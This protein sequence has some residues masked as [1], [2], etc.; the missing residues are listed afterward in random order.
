[1]IDNQLYIYL[2]GVAGVAYILWEVFNGRRVRKQRQQF[3]TRGDLATQQ[4]SDLSLTDSVTLDRSA[5]TIPLSSARSADLP[6]ENAAQSIDGKTPEPNTPGA[7]VSLRNLTLDQDAIERAARERVI[8]EQA[9]L[10]RARAQQAALEQARAQQAERDRIRAEHDR[11]EA[12]RK[13]AEDAERFA[14]AASRVHKQWCEKERKVEAQYNKQ[15]IAVTERL[16]RARR[17]VQDSGVGEA[18][19]NA[20]RMMWHWPALQAKDEWSRPAGMNE[21]VLDPPLAEKSDSHNVISWLWIDRHYRI[22]LDVPDEQ[23]SE[24]E[25]S[26]VLTLQVDGEGVLSIDVSNPVGGAIERWDISGVDALKAGPWMPEF[27]EIIERLKSGEAEK[28]RQMRFE[29]AAGKANRVE[30]GEEQR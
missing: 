9:A 5:S 17:L 11:I 20:L 2:M 10:E 14:M 3:G 28:Q 30:F 23:K 12:E 18:A 29:R 1:M 27:V 22:D 16:E 6:N 19:I 26:G 21:L 8:A 13:A 25:R 24:D 15:M 7:P 4:A